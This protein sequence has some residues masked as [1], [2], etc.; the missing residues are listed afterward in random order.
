MAIK[1][2]RVVIDVKNKLK[3]HLFKWIDDH[4][5]HI[6]NEKIFV[7]K[8]YNQIVY[9]YIIMNNLFIYCQSKGVE[10]AGLAV[11]IVSEWIKSKK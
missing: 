3:N 9:P 11:Y 1:K 2:N 5:Q 4:Y 6:P 7:M 10:K 8:E